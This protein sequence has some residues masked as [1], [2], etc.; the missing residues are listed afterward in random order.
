MSAQLYEFLCVN[1]GRRIAHRRLLTRAS[2]FRVVETGQ[3]P[4]GYS[5]TANCNQ[6][7]SIWTD[8]DAVYAVSMICKDHDHR[9]GDRIDKMNRAAQSDSQIV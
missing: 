1:N 5:R 4:D 8:R 9:M 3:L 7:G 6:P 2:A